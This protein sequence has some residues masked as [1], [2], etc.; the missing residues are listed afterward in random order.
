MM[1]SGK[2]QL[3]WMGLLAAQATAAEPFEGWTPT[4][5]TWKA[6]GEVLAQTEL[7]ADCRA[8][9]PQAEWTDYVYE[10]KARKTGGNEG[11]LILFRVKDRQHFYWWNIGGWGNTQHAIETR[12]QRVFDRK[13]G[14]I[15]TGRWYDIRIVV[16]GDSIKC[17]LDGTLIHDI[18][19][20]TYPAGGIG[21]GAWSTAAEYKDVAVTTLDGRKLYG[22]DKMSLAEG[23][24]KELGEAGDG[25]RREAAALRTA[26]AKPDDPR[27]APLYERAATLRDRLRAARQAIEA[28]DLAAPRAALQRLAAG[29]PAA[30]AEAEGL[31]AELSAHGKTLDGLREALAQGRQPDLAA[32]GKIQETV[33]KVAAFE[34][35]LFIHRCPPIAFVKR[36]SHGL[37]GTNAT[38]HSR[39]TGVG[40]AICVYDPDKPDQPPRII[41]EDKTGFIMDISPS[42][43]GKRLV[44]TYKR[45]VPKRED[46]HHIWEINTDGTGLRQVTTG[47]FHDFNPVYLPDGRICFASTR[48]EAYSMCQDF[49]ACALYVVN[50][51]GSDIRRLEYSTLCDLSPAVL[52]DGSILFTRWEYQDK[53]IFCT[54]ALWTINPDGTRLQLFYGN[55]LTVPNAI[56][57]AKQIPGTRKLLATMA[58]HHHPPLGAV[59]V[60]D[61]SLGHESVEGIVNITPEVPYRP[62]VGKTWRETSWGPGDILYPWSYTDP[63]PLEE[64]LYLVSYGGP[65]KGG[66][67]RYRLF[68]ID[69][70]GNKALLYDDPQASCFCPVPLRPRQR[71]HQFVGAPPADPKGE[72]RFFCLDVYQ[73]LLDKGVKRGQVKELRIMEQLPKKYNT[74]GPRYSDHYPAIG[75]GTYYVKYNHGTVPVAEDGSV[76]F[77][78]PA[79]VELY[80]Q[81][82]DKDGKEIRRMG[83]VTQ[84]VPGEAQSCIG[85][86]ESRSLAPPAD[87][88]SWRRLNRPPDR[89]T[90]PPWGAG[91]VDFVAQVQ[92]VLDKY[93]VKC[94]SGPRPDGGVD[95]SGD[96]TRLFNMA[97]E[98]L[99]FTPGLV[100]RYHINPGPTG[101]FPPLATG[102]WV[103]RLTKLL[104]EK[105][106][107]LGV[108]DQSRRRIYTWID[109]N[110]PYYGTWEMTRPH[111]FGGRDTWLDERGK[112]LPWFAD[113]QKALAGLRPADP[114][115]MQTTMPGRQNPAALRHADI[116]LTHPEWS[117]V[118]TRNLAKSA[119]GLADDAKAIF[120]SKD[121][122]RYR[123]ILEAI[124]AGKAALLARPRIDMPGAVPIPQKR[125][126]GRTF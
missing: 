58:A 110:V 45:D 74:E 2:S 79:G 119:G 46:S 114:P 25:L 12:P 89:I 95:L 61:R 94:H 56:Y 124:E 50:A 43:D 54:E 20:A 75:E 121:D 5:G 99:V 18:K 97:F 126:F 118:L 81:A 57:G 113:L 65:L 85:C 6:E 84:L 77:I 41:F 26:G 28:I 27:W 52:D 53:N 116:N 100:D 35:K 90:P 37:T 59:C 69:S 111:S 51:D 4:A 11:F 3:L 33:R 64:D 104:E 83:T 40:S 17:Y 48:V 42:Y 108:D 106:K 34:R 23:C 115:N 66:P 70:K 87:I 109:A 10:L 92:P 78:A 16:Q 122:P 31:L 103:S 86:H 62:T 101:N 80:F 15:E 24:L 112:P 105:Y 123:A 71:P 63:Y 98:T 1:V 44:F 91:P 38:M 8:F 107:H 32:L 21:L 117:R 22:L 49:L 14:Q 93:C 55:T 36:S 76:Y 29:F 72:G 68:V 88:Q 102:S 60:I 19:E 30:K 82:L 9:A 47:R 73:G 120:K 96:K 13:P 39:I 125:D 7:R 67:Q